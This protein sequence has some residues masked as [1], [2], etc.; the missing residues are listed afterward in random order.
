LASGRQKD[1]ISKE[2]LQ[3][4]SQLTS[5]IPP[6]EKAVALGIYTA[7]TGKW[8]EEQSLEEL[9]T[10]AITAGADVRRIYLQEKPRQDPAFYCGKGKL[11]EVREFCAGHNID[12]VLFDDPLSPAQMRNIEKVLDCKVL[13]RTQLILDIFAQRAKTA[14]GKLQVELAQI[15]YFLPR[16]TGKG[17]ALSRLGG[18]IGTRGPGETKLEF[19]RR[20]LRERRTRLLKQLEHVKQIRSLQ[21]SSRS[22]IPLPTVALIGYTN[23]GK[24]T[25]FNRL[26]GSKGFAS[27]ILFAT[28]DPA[29]KSI[30]AANKQ[31]ILIS[32]TVGFIQ[33]LPHEL[34]AAFRATL[35][36]V[37]QAHLLLH[38]IDVANP[39]V[40]EQIDA[41][42]QTIKELGVEGKPVI[43]VL[44]K[45][46]L[47]ENDTAMLQSFRIQLGNVVAISAETGRGLEELVKT[48]A[49]TLTDFW[50]RIHLSIPLREQSLIAQLHDQGKVYARNY[51]DEHIE[52]DVEL[53]KKLAEKLRQYALS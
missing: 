23:A 46:D 21:R 11:E 25:L 40:D 22:E 36:E 35:E 45:I 47:L 42:Q 8:K 14:E 50:Q 52:L 27:P 20:R 43:H 48:I 26:T 13:D 38:V 30:R 5:L 39:N 10:L 53:P 29:M 1:I 6:K 2:A 17:I 33:K 18:G 3:K 19:D 15:D 9:S 4:K 16:L 49:D 7:R 28:L 12:L 37:V 51:T 31:L 41:V 24:T 32:D 34:V 44:N